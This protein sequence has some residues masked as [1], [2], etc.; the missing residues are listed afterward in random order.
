MPASTRGKERDQLTFVMVNSVLAY[1]WKTRDLSADA[2]V[3]A[4]DLTTGLGHM[5]AVQ[6]LA[7]QG[8]VLVI[9]ANAPK[10]IRV[11]KRIPD[12]VSPAPASVSTFCGYDKLASANAAGFELSG[13]ARTISLAAPAANRRTYSGV[14]TLS[15]GLK[16]VQPVDFIAGTADRRQ[17][18]G[19]EI[20]SEIS[21]VEALK[22]ARGC[23][24]KPGRVAIDLEGGVT[25]RLPFS[26]DRQ[27]QAGALG[28]IVELEQVKY[29]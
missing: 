18:L 11:I 29:Q 5:D 23:R 7:V 28:S 10:P 20:A 3:S 16:Y 27:E 15:N 26:T 14:V 22:L 13:R 2:G 24:D 17:A 21:A 12:A 9:G 1:G 4:A 25:A 8:S 19:I 6:A